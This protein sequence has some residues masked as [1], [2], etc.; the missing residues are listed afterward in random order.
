MECGLSVVEKS[1]GKTRFL[2]LDRD[3]VIN[4]RIPDGYVTSWE[5]FEYLPR[6]LEALQLLAR[7]GYAALV[8]S[9]QACVGKGLLSAREL[10]L[11]TQRFVSEVSAAGGDIRGV[12]YCIHVEEEHCSCRKPQPGLL[13]R[14]QREH[15]FRFAETFMIGDSFSDIEAARRVGSPAILVSSS[16]PPACGVV[17]QDLPVVH[18]LYEAVNFV[19]AAERAGHD[20]FAGHEARSEG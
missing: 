6:A 20:A 2:L 16:V 5:A 10:E 18:S 3:G 13:A 9:N 12:Y 17:T 8:I 14:A 4:R 19:L 1:L 15:G 7:H 11:M